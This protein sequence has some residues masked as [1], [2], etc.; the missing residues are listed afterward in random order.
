M[1]DTNICYSKFKQQSAT[2]TDYFEVNKHN[3]Q[4]Q[5]LLGWMVSPL[6]EEIVFGEPLLREINSQFKILR[7]GIIRMET[8]RCYKWHVDMYRGVTIN[9]LLTP[10]SQSHCYF[11]DS[12]D[13]Y[14]EQ[15]NFIELKYTK[16]EF[17]LF[18][19]DIIHTV[20]N[21]NEPRYL[22]TIEFAQPKHELSYEVVR[23]WS[24]DKGLI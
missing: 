11:G 19:T 9:M 22:F 18:N 13:E 6:P 12:N 5:P 4:Y 10:E 15:F 14:Q 24:I 21:Y 8:N 1:I 23:Q 16:N 20:L 17:Y 2:I 7:A 3:L